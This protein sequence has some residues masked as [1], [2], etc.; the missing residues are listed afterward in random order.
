M[1]SLEII[2]KTLVIKSKTLVNNRL[3]WSNISSFIR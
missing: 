1:N 2:T 3:S